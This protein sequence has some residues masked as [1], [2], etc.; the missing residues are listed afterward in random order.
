MSGGE[1]ER[2]PCTGAVVVPVHGEIDIATATAMRDRILH[3]AGRS[4]C[5]CVLVDLSG[6]TFL[7]AS[8]VRE[9]MVVYR[10][11]TREGR[12]MVLAEPSSTA[13]RILDALRLQEVLEIYPMVDMALAHPRQGCPDS[14]RV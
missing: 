3:A 4:G 13:Q 11:L 9:L 12:H 5:A 1:W 14:G 10:S 8:G 2:F 7:D 6:V